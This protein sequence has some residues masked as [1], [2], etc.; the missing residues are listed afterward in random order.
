MTTDLL[1]EIAQ[2]TED[3]TGRGIALAIGSLVGDGA[4]RPGDQLP[5]VRALAAHLG[6]SPNTVAEAWR[7]LQ[8]HGAISTDRRRGTQ[9]R[10]R[11]VRLD[12]RYWQVPVAPGTIELDLS[13]G[14]PDEALLPPL[15]PVLHRLHADVTFS[16]YVDP[17][18]VAALETEIRHRWPYEPEAITIVDG[19]QDALD[20]LVGE[21]VGIGDTVVVEDPTF[22]P[23]IDMLELAGARV[24]GVPVDPDGIEVDGLR[25]AMSTDPVAVWLQPRAHNPTGTIMTGDRR[26]AIA[27]LIGGTRTLVVEDDHS[28]D[29]SGAA[30]HSVGVGLPDQ[31]VH[32]H[33]FSK[34]HGPDLRIAAIGGPTSVLDGVVRRRTLG[35]AWTSRLVQQILLVMLQDPEIEQTVAAAADAYA[36]RRAAL[37]DGLAARGVAVGRGAGLNLW[38]PVEDEQRAV[39][40][41]AAHGVGVAPGAPFR[42]ADEPDHHIRVSL[43]TLPDD[44]VDEVASTIAAVAT[45]AHLDW[46]TRD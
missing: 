7:L 42:V 20:R 31:V 15:G 38:V 6:V 39:V 37:E 3:R 1:D 5:T 22:P 14:T 16:S 46:A 41:L 27:R 29:A 26:D 45:G 4:L 17:P 24:I 44:R 10:A 32:I 12:G 8:T 25:E 21:L 13:T 23:L 35:P 34:S 18:I 11:Q 43:G 19:A 2:R 36:R 30:I 40:A 9:V 28:G 33:S